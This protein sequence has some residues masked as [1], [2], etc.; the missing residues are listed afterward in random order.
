MLKCRL[1]WKAMSFEWEKSG[2]Y[3]SL[4]MLCGVSHMFSQYLS[5]FYCFYSRGRDTAEWRA[6]V[7]RL[8][9]QMPT[10]AII[11]QAQSRCQESLQ[12]S[13][14]EAGTRTCARVCQ[15]LPG[16]AASQECWLE[17]WFTV[18]INLHEN[19]ESQDLPLSL[20]C[21]QLFCLPN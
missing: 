12:I 15:D 8:A 4:D 20:P 3:L 6:S 2:F 9:P 19:R 10:T 16:S 1:Y 11:G 5:L 21:S 14:G 7:C 13:T 18:K 17:T